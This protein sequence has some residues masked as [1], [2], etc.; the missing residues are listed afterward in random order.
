M[1]T[2]FM[3]SV[4]IIYGTCTIIIV[5]HT[6]DDLS[7]KYQS[8]PTSSSTPTTTD[9]TLQ[10]KTELNSETTQVQS[11]NAS[12]KAKNVTMTTIMLAVHQTV[13]FSLKG[14]DGSIVAKGTVLPGHDTIHG[15][16]CKD[17]CQVV[18]VTDIVQVGAQPY[19]FDEGLSKGIC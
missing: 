19:R 6:V 13:W 15:H 9:P 1:L 11:S 5:I 7:N 2:S 17:N 16:P 18:A 4:S 12:S 10:D 3:V 8:V 14:K